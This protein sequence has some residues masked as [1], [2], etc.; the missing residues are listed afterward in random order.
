M[1]RLTAIAAAVVAFAILPLGAVAAPPGGGSGSQ[2]PAKPAVHWFAGSVTTVGSDSLGVDVLW[3]G[4]KDGQLNG[5][6]VSVAL[7][8]DTQIVEGK[9]HSAASLSDIVPGDL[10]SLR[11]TAAD[12]TLS[13]LTAT[14]IRIWC[15]CHWVG[16]TING[17]GSSSI[18]VHVDRTGPYDTVM[19]G[20]D[21]TIQVNGSTTYIKGKDKTPISLSDLQV[22]AG[23]GIVFGANG[24]FKAPGFDPEKATFTASRVHE[25]LKRQVPPPSSDAGSAA[26]TTP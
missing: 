21:V 24:F 7:N 6:T 8:G 15:N 1:F 4:P 12:A 20:T 5:T 25:W 26:G 18:S 23:I 10:V 22:G 11:A 14:H 9:D 2:A 3:T 16:G 13:S 17:V 19:K